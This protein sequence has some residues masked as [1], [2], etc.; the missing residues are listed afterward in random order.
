MKI[1]AGSLFSMSSR[2]FFPVI[3]L[4]LPAFTMDEGGVCQLLTKQV[5][6]SFIIGYTWFVY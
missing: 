1:L 3:D 4:P 5:N 2:S 6:R